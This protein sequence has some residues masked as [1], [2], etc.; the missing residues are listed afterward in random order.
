MAQ[1][2]NNLMNA[3]GEFL[4][5]DKVQFQ[6]L[7]DEY[8]DAADEEI[9]DL[10]VAEDEA[11]KAHY[12]DRKRHASRW[13]DEYHIKDSEFR[14]K[15]YRSDVLK[16]RRFSKAERDGE[17]WYVLKYDKLPNGAYI[18]R[19]KFVHKSKL[20]KPMDKKA[21]DIGF[22][23]EIDEPV[24]SD[25]PVDS[26]TIDPLYGEWIKWK[27]STEKIRELEAENAEL[28]I[29]NARLVNEYNKMRSDIISYLMEMDL[30]D[31]FTAWVAR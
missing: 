7:L 2:V 21:K 23:T 10:L 4:S 13:I 1:N 11:V 25:N 30:M 3:L 20:W 12:D 27:T 26:S 5:L 15:K 24:V 28:R 19:D 9:K 16:K 29:E 8:N 31:D 22:A 6:S 18:V 17:V 14:V